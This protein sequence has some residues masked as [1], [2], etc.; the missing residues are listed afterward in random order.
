VM[1]ATALTVN[2]LL[3]PDWQQMLAVQ[4]WFVLSCL[5]ALLL[6]LPH[7]TKWSAK[8]HASLDEAEMR[9]FLKGVFIVLAIALAM[10]ALRQLQA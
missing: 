1:A 9:F 3:L 10:S 7:A 6:V 2:G 8:L 5:S 4:K